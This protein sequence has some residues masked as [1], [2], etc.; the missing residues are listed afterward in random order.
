MNVEEN[1][2]DFNF[3]KEKTGKELSNAVLTKIEALGLNITDCWGQGFNNVKNMKGQ[4]Q[5]I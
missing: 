3:I 2:I 1:F 4:N 5:G